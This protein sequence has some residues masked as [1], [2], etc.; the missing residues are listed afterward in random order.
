MKCGEKLIPYIFQSLSDLVFS[1]KTF[2]TFKNNTSISHVTDLKFA[3]SQLA[4]AAA[5]AGK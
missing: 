1:A 3:V 5:N 4:R 2:S